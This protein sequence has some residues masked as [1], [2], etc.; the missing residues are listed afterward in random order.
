[1]WR[2]TGESAS[3]PRSDSRRPGPDP[4]GPAAARPFCSQ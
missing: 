1:L 4:A 2:G 3:G